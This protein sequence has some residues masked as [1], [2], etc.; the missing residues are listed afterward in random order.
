MRLP[1]GIEDD[2][3]VRAAL[4]WL[5]DVSGNPAGFGRRL[6][7][8]QQAYIDYTGAPSNFGRDPALSAL[9]ADVVGS[10][11]AQAQSLLDGRRSFDQALASR[12]VPWLKQIGVNVG[13]LANVPGAAHRARRMLEDA[14]SDPDGP[15][16]ELVMAGNYAAEGEQ[17]AFVP[18]QPGQA[19]TPD[20]HLTVDGHSDCVAIEFKRLRAGKYEAD[21]REM[22]RRI[23][24]RAAEIV[25][26][27]QLSLCIDVTYNIELNDVPETYLADWLLRF[28]SSP[29]FTPGRY[30][31]CDEFGSGEIRR[32]NVEAVLEDIKGSSLYFGTKLARLLTGNPV[33]EGGYNLAAGLVPDDRDPRFFQDF[34]YGSVVTWQCIA[35]AA[36][37]RKARH[38]K[39]KLAEAGRQ[40]ATQRVGVI[41]LAMD[42][43]LGCKSSDL[44]RQRNTEV[45]TEFRAESLVVALYVHYLVPRIFEAHSWLI[46]ETC[47]KFGHD[48]E[49]P[50]MMIF[51]GSQALGNDLPAWQQTVP[52]PGRL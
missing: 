37:E 40:V 38:V 35:P 27:R 4:R 29:L 20:V 10:F 46:D 31:W 26:G 3:D 33:R 15:M 13:A 2:A 44:R 30:P 9:G 32:A 11:L 12:C 23:F 21:E 49:P 42:V 51:P 22:Q 25:D 17:V 14:S 48:G 24:R 1:E 18:E 41:H 19:R 16:L 8:A 39:T 36:M 50:T 5:A 47:D 43:E 52:I 7:T 45:I 28:L 34:R 6:R